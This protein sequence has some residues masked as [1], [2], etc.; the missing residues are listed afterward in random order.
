MKNRFS[1]LFAVALIFVSLIMVLAISASA[2]YG[3]TCTVYYKDES[4]KEIAPRITFTVDAGEPS[5]HQNGVTSPSIDGYSLKNSSDSFVSYAMM[6]KNFPASN[7]VREGTAT[8]TVYYIKNQSTT[9]YF[10]YSDGSEAYPS[11]TLS[12]N[13][14]ANF[15]TYSPSITGYSPSK[16]SCSGKYG[17]ASQTV[18]YYELTYTV[19]FNM[20][21]GTGSISSQT[22]RYFSDLKLTSSVPT[23]TGYVFK[24]WGTSSTD[25]VVDFSPGGTYSH[26]M[27]MT[28]YAIWE[29]AT[30]TVSYD[31]NGG[32][33]APESQIKTYGEDLTL[34]TSVPSRSNHVFMGWSTSSSSSS[35][36]Y[37]SGDTYAA[38]AP[39]TLYAVWLERNYDFSISD[40]QINPSTVYQYETIN[41]SFR[42]ESWDKNF[43]YSNIPIE[44]LV[45]GNV[46]YSTSITFTKYAVKNFSLDV[47]VGSGVGVQTVVAR[48]N[49]SKRTSEKDSSD[50]SVSET[51]KV[52]KIVE[53][54]VQPI[55]PNGEYIEGFEVITSFYIS[56]SETRDILP[57]DEIAF[58]FTVYQI[59]S[60]SIKIIKNQ[61]LDSI[62]IP[63]GGKNLV[64]FKWRIPE[65]SVGCTYYCRGTVNVYDSKYES[66]PNDNAKEL[67][68]KIKSVT[69]S[70]T[71]NTVFE[72]SAPTSYNPN[73]S[74]EESKF[75]SAAWN[76]WV[77]ENGNLVLKS[78]RVGVCEDKPLLAPSEDCKSVITNENGWTMKSGYGV[79]LTWLPCAVAM[80][81]YDM[82]SEDAYTDAQFASALF[83][84]YSYSELKGEYRTL[85]YE[86]GVYRFAENADSESGE[87]LHF[88]PLY[89]KDGA[90]IVT[91]HVSHIWTPAGMI[92]AIVNTDSIIINGTLYDDFYVGK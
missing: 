63:A 77:Y 52:K 17:S 49:W 27:N 15:V 60:G 31:A 16:T 2:Y 71:V 48:I 38:N 9:I 59:E 7:Y 35:I 72:K 40:L 47:N 46:V 68:V 64:Y 12:G 43:G 13:P 8:Y 82:P 20:N 23:R 36:A 51:F 75:G 56:N 61:I 24:G 6:D 67:T 4:G 22:K 30:Y 81:D 65:S 66:N 25:T 78:Y 41:I 86:G 34:T 28:L 92:S 14:S 45:N 32:Y 10:K 57:S 85:V 54:S 18:Y 62:V 89:I 87:R 11:R 42:T 33:N 88:V 91:A 79:T 76:M 3:M 21:G 19:S 58:A 26:N 70:Q 37:N 80:D 73:K 90:Y 83:P 50:N 29:K 55:E 53:T 74:A 39:I 5:Q 1:K 44:V 69:E 84:E